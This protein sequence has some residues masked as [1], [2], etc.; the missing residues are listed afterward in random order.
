MFFVFGPQFVMQYS[1]PFL[2]C[3]HLTEEER[4][5]CFTVIVFLLPCGCTCYMS[6]PR[7]TMRSWS[8][9]VA[10]P[11]HTHLLFMLFV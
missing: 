4:A 9:T 8:L 6:L 2:D 5:G 10:F 3:N 7:G 11:G 1:V